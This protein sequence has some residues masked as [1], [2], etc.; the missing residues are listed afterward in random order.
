VRTLITAGTVFTPSESILNGAVLIDDG[1]IES[2]GPR[3]SFSAS[4][5]RVLDFPNDILAP[6]FIDIHIHGAAGHDFMQA[7][8]DAYRKIGRFLARHGTTSYLPTTMT[9]AEDELLPALAAMGNAIATPPQGTETAPCARPIGIHLEGPFI[10]DARNG[11]H[12]AAHIQKPSV[13][14]LD[15]YVNAARGAIRVVTIAP[16]TQHAL[17]VIRDAV[18][19]GITVAFGHTNATFEEAQQAIDAGARHST[20]TYNSMRRMIHREPGVVGAILSDQRMYADI[21]ADGL[22][23]HP[24]IVD[25]FLRCKGRDRAILISD[26]TSPTG[27]PNG[28]YRLGN[29]EVEV[30]GLRVES[31]GKLA[32]SVITLEVAVQ[33]VMQ[34]AGWSLADA[35]RLVTINPAQLLGLEKKGR[36]AAGAD[37][38]LVILSPEAEVRRTFISGQGI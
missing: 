13:V 24:P 28:S 10:S 35:V 11:V 3:T 21:I 33:N 9:S 16:E 7:G 25:L 6:G 19:R 18:D 5:A 22:H 17:A 30:D 2:V 32:G 23:V 1:R 20:H 34:Y 38:D 36:I 14:A 4:D 12:P 26:A 37:A 15:R 31:H 29:F 8:E 27:M